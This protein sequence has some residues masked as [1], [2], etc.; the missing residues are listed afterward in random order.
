MERALETVFGVTRPTDNVPA[1]GRTDRAIT[2]DLFEFHGI[3]GDSE[4]WT[5]FTTAYFQLLPEALRQLD[6]RILPGV[7]E[8]LDQLS[9]RED[10]VLGLLTGNFREGARLKL[11]HYGLDRHFPFG[12]F[13]DEHFHRDDVAREALQALE[14]HVG[15]PAANEQVWVIGDTPSDVSCA[16]AIG[17]RAVAVATGIY[18]YDDLKPT[19]PDCLLPNLANAAP[20]LQLLD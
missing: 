15:R 3:T 9:V 4:A 2:T 16:R 5:Q 10:V 17:A 18:S 6:G 13:G 7:P 8:L 1:A 11:E 20:W 12:G 19:K 14:Q